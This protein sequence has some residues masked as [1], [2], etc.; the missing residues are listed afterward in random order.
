VGLYKV[1][2]AAAAI[3][4]RLA[5]PPYAALLPRISK[6]WAAHRGREIRRLVERAT[7]ISVPVMTAALGLVILLQSPILSVLG[8]DDAQGADTVLVLAAIAQA[9]NGA[10]FWNVGVLYVAGRSNLVARIA[11]AGAAAQLLL[12][13]PL[14]TTLE[15]DGAALSYL[16]SMLGTNLVAVWCAG[17]VLR[18][19]N[20]EATPR[21]QP[22]PEL[23]AP[24]EI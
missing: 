9:V 4:G 22:A 17:A 19:P 21:H 8:G 12:L 24:G 23:T 13:V 1:G 5:D 2:M 11:L 16:V 6:L 20:G 15:A 3:V 10:L 7:L 18:R 14:V